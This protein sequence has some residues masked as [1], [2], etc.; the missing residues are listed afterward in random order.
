MK[1]NSDNARSSAVIDIIIGLKAH[2]INVIIYDN[3]ISGY[4]YM[5]YPVIK[6]INQFK[7]SADVIISNRMSNDLIDVENKVYTRDLFKRD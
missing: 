7:Q 2:G 6:D 1:A 3:A 5:G 4:A